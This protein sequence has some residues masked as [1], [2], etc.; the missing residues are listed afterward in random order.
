M[1]LHC[2]DPEFRPHSR[3]NVLKS[4]VQ[5]I[6]SINVANI[7]ITALGRVCVCLIP[8]DILTTDFATHTESQPTAAFS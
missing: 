6:S 1:F 7:E 2:R 8:S 4:V 3:E 5:T